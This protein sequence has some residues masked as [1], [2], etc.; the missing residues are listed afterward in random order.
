MGYTL[1]YGSTSTRTRYIY[2]VSFDFIKEKYFSLL[3]SFGRSRLCW[4]V[5]CICSMCMVYKCVY[6]TRS[7]WWHVFLFKKTV[8]F[9][10]F[11]F[12]FQ[13]DFFFIC[14]SSLEMCT[15]TMYVQRTHFLWAFFHRSWLYIGWHIRERETCFVSFRIN[16]W[17]VKIVS[18]GFIQLNEFYFYTHFNIPYTYRSCICFF[19]FVLFL[20]WNYLSHSSFP[21]ERKICIP[22]FFLS[23]VLLWMMR[24]NQIVSKR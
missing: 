3:R 11:F 12:R 19:S 10:C 22:F 9:V 2:L 16:E 5:L 6:R 21:F 20:F 7:Q 24:Q 15:S 18:G 14:H 13:F 17:R 1:P 8:D 4:M 23:F